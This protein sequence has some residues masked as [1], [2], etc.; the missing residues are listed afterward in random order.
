MT[1]DNL[2]LEHQEK[3]RS[4][5]SSILDK[6]SL[7]KREESKSFKCPPTKEL[8][9]LQKALASRMPE[10]EKSCATLS[11]EAKSFSGSKFNR[12]MSELKK[13]L[14]NQSLIPIISDKDDTNSVRSSISESSNDDYLND[15]RIQ[16]KSR[17]R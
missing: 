10:E 9:P 17:L 6:I 1:L 13:R 4:A 16:E 2:C 3:Q 15:L 12:R 8:T 5:S 14:T 7:K 11:S